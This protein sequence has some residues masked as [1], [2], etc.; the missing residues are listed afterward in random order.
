MAP[1][2]KRLFRVLKNM[3]VFFGAMVFATCCTAADPA[4][5]PTTTP[6]AESTSP[7]KTTVI[8]RGHTDAL[9]NLAFL[10]DGR[11]IL[12]CSADMTIRLWDSYTGKELRQFPGHTF[13]INSLAVSRD[14]KT[15]A[16]ASQDATVRLWDIDTGKQLAI[17]KMLDNGSSSGLSFSPDGKYLAINDTDPHWDE[18]TGKSTGLIQLLDSKTLEVK[19]TFQDKRFGRMWLESFSP[20][21]K[22][23]VAGLESDL[24]IDGHSH[25]DGGW[26]MWDVETGKAIFSLSTH[27]ADT[28]EAR[29]SPDG[30][31]F[32]TAC[33][34]DL[35]LWDAATG[36][37]LGHKEMPTA[38]GAIAW[39]PDGAMF[40]T[41]GW[42]DVCALWE[43]ATFRQI[44]SFN[45][46]WNFAPGAGITGLEF[47]PDGT[48]LAAGE[49]DTNLVRIYNVPK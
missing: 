29:F 13:N 19:R 14:G 8:L 7:P 5:A 31:K 35:R 4:T 26:V 11:R 21:G 34:G 9:T 43:P 10:P 39:R 3:L 15:F 47:S 28:G 23:I 32:L 20:N 46:G 2:M 37:E 36:K 1:K 44:K 42:S 49:S 40:A 12:T 18:V 33:L 16:S 27:R 30:T 38:A 25:N 6:N 24:Q 45:Q 22:T 17:H 48:R 41:G